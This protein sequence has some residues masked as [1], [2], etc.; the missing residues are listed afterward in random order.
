MKGV[1]PTPRTNYDGGLNREVDAAK[2]TI[3]AGRCPTG[4]RYLLRQQQ[5]RDDEVSLHSKSRWRYDNRRLVRFGGE[6]HLAGFVLM[7]NVVHATR[8]DCTGLIGPFTPRYD[9]PRSR[10]PHRLS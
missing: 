6:L 5:E 8:S 10:V 4:T 7:P 2:R 3:T 1:R 9:A